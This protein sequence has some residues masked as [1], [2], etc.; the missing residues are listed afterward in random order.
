MIQASGTITIGI[1]QYTNPVINV[2]MTSASKYVDTLGIAQI[3]IIN[4]AT[5]DSK[6][7]FIP[8]AIAG[9][10]LYSN[11]NPSFEE[12]QDAVIS[13]LEKDYPSVIFDKSLLSL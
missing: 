12:V 1:A 6:K 7:E 2:Y 5:E 4:Q 13:G 9:T 3:G 8:L 11:P 10:Y